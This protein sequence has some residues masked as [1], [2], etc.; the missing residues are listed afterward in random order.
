MRGRLHS[1]ETRKIM[2]LS[3]QTTNHIKTH[4]IQLLNA[5]IKFGVLTS[6]MV[7]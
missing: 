7:Q 4:T 1:F 2:F 5:S 6:I 3:K